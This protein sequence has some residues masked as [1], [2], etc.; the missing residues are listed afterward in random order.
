MFK[1]HFLCSN[2]IIIATGNMRQHDY[3]VLDPLKFD[4]V[5]INGQ[6]KFDIV[7]AV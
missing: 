4:R 2:N 1:Y 5:M 3:Y 6:L 7:L